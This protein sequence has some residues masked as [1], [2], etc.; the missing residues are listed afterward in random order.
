MYGVATV[1]R[2]DKILGLFCRISSLLQKRPII[3][4][5]LLAK[6][7]PYVNESHLF[8]YDM[9]VRDSFIYEMTRSYVTW[10]TQSWHDSFMRD[11][12]HS[13]VAWLIYTWHESFIRTRPLKTSGHRPRLTHIVIKVQIYGSPSKSSMIHDHTCDMGWLRLVGSLKT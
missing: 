1:S 8:M 9:T 2:I 3:L 7:T 10:L 5:I 13:Y 4:S 12:A 11:M 6:A